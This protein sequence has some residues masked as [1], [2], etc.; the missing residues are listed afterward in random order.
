MGNRLTGE[1]V[2]TFKEA[3]FETLV[4]YALHEML[5][6]IQDVKPALVDYWYEIEKGTT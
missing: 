2:P 3:D 6:E 1:W 5:I 4:E